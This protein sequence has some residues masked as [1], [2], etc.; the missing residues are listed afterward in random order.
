MSEATIRPEANHSPRRAWIG[1]ISLLVLAL[2]TVLAVF[3]WYDPGLRHQWDAA[4]YILTAKSLLAGEGYTYLGQPFF[5]RPPGNAWLIA[6]FLGPGG[7][8][9]P[10]LLNRVMM[11]FAATSVVALFVLLR[12]Q[13]RAWLA[14]GAACLTGTCPGVVTWFNYVLADFPFL[15]L[16]FAG[17]ALMQVAGR[18]ERGWWIWSVAGALALAASFYLRSLAVLL[19]PV[20]PLV[21]W[22]RD[23]GL[24]HWRGLLPAALMLALVLPWM[25]HAREAASQAERPAEQL[26]LFDYG[27]GV[28]HV[29]P[30]DPNS[31][32][33][34]VPELFRRAALNAGKI[35]ASV[36]KHFLGT[37]NSSLAW[38][39][40][41][42]IA[43]GVA[44][45]LRRGPT[46]SDWFGLTYLGTMLGFF[47]FEE[48]L[49]LP[50]IAPA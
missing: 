43:V 1:W 48:R 44:R 15:T 14:L 30:G 11:V 37:R 36:E 26:L 28:F 32:R 41:A 10:S 31:P 13:Q 19:L 22:S 46:L 12:Q 25:A 7:G 50:W 47:T 24:G 42:L 21:G 20:L 23:K 17:M 29:H 49:I 2:Y 16:A 18:R 6:Q 39:L 9:D 4:L 45:Q 40:A 5:L 3:V 33:V 38:V 35:G 8:F 27:T 34:P